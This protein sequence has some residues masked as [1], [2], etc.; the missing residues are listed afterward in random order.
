MPEGLVSRARYERERAARREAEALLEAKSREL[1][2]AREA[3]RRFLVRINHEFR[4]PLNGIIAPAQLLQTLEAPEAVGRYASVIERSGHELMDLLLTVD[5]AARSSSVPREE[6]ACAK[7]TVL[8]VDDNNVNRM[9]ARAAAEAVGLSVKEAADGRAAL[10]ALEEG[11]ADLVLMDIQMPVMRGDEAILAIRASAAPYAAIP[12]I[13]LTADAEP[14]GEARYR[15]MGA[16]G[17]LTK[18]VA[19]AALG[20]ALKEA[21]ARSVRCL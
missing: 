1:Y 10:A 21:V 13:V 18:P 12:I 7:A 16:D 15:E 3:E 2:E 8:V 9:V 17:Y 14:D 6:G 19:I 4:T 20:K 5:A 11:P